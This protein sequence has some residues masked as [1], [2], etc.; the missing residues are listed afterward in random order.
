VTTSIYSNLSPDDLVLARSTPL[1]FIPNIPMPPLPPQLGSGKN[2]Q[3]QPDRSMVR[4][5][6]AMSHLG[7]ADVARLTNDLG[8]ARD[9]FRTALGIFESL[10]A[11]GE[12]ANISAPSGPERP[13]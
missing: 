13:V 1:K 11:S 7:L 9:H 8:S 4:Y 3:R 6:I 2:A 12:E 10:N 5:G